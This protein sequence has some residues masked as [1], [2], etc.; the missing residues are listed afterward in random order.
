MS[1]YNVWV[2]GESPWSRSY[3]GEIG[4]FPLTEAQVKRWVVEDEDGDLDI[5]SIS[6]RFHRDWDAEE[7][8]EDDFPSRCQIED[9]CMGYGAYIDQTFGVADASTDE[10]IWSGEYHELAY[11]ED[12]DEEEICARKSVVCEEPWA[13]FDEVK[14]EFNYITGVAYNYCHKGGWGAEVEIPDGEE[15]DVRK[16]TFNVIEVD[17]LGEVVISFEYDGVEYFDEN[18]SDGKGNDYYLVHDCEFS[19]L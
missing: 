4:F 5:E 3:M 7:D 19:S 16:L 13:R 12:A 14:N 1:S 17:G 18:D 10:I 8:G 2:G 11:V 6:E 9:G 15:F